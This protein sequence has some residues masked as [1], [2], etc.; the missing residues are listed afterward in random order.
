MADAL[1]TPERKSRLAMNDQAPAAA[2]APPHLQPV[3]PEPHAE[4]VAGFEESLEA[5]SYCTG[6]QIFVPEGGY[7]ST[8]SCIKCGK[9]SRHIDLAKLRSPS[10]P[11]TWFGKRPE[12]N[13]GLC[14]KHHENHIVAVALTWSILIVGAVLL[15][16]GIFSMSLV[17]I[18]V[19]LFA[20]GVSGIF[21]ATSPVTSCRDCKSQGNLMI[22]GAS[23]AYRKQV[24]LRQSATTQSEE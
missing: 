6:K 5:L 20:M 16:A 14:R 21:R 13:V 1:I 12:M 11:R 7:L 22:N 10:D 23:D 3:P 4:V 19:G 18:V 9:P 17:S 2:S 24:R 15:L 8:E